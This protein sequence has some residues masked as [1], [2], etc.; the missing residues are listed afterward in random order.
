[1]SETLQFNNDDRVP[2][3]TAL[4]S[5]LKERIPEAA[6]YV[7]GQATL[8]DFHVA[9]APVGYLFYQMWNYAPSRAMA[10][11]PAP[12][13]RSDTWG[14]LLKYMDAKLHDP[15]SF[16]PLL[17]RFE[18]AIQGYRPYEDERRFELTDGRCTEIEGLYSFWQLNFRNTKTTIGDSE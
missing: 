11:S 5:R 7:I 12:Q 9:P 2:L 6:L 15:R 13:V 14:L 17:K 16:F 8:K 18:Q 3:L 10:G 1:M 4:E